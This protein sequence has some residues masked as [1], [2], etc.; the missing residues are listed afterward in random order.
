[1][2]FHLEPF[3]ACISF[4]SYVYA[5]DFWCYN[6]TSAQSGCGPPLDVRTQHWKYCTGVPVYE[7]MCVKIIEKVNGRRFHLYC[8]FY[9]FSKV[10]FNGIIDNENTKE[11]IVI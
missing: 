3:V 7:Q 2:K 9:E 4:I 1:M 6:C 5:S 11:L 8:M 10:I